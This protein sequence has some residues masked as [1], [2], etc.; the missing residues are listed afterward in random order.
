MIGDE[1]SLIESLSGGHSGFSA[2]AEAAIGF[3]LQGGGGEWYWVCFSSLSLF[4]IL[5]DKIRGG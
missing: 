5:Y 3:N 4:N 1:P 2:V